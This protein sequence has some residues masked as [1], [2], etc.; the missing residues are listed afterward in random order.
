MANTINNS[1]PLP[2]LDSRY[3]DTAALQKQSPA[4][5]KTAATVDSFYNNQLTKDYNTVQN[6]S[7]SGITDHQSEAKLAADISLLQSMEKQFAG[8]TGDTATVNRLQANPDQTTEGVT[9]NQILEGSGSTHAKDT[10]FTFTGSGT[11]GNQQIEAHLKDDPSVQGTAAFDTTDDSVA[12]STSST[13]KGKDWSVSNSSGA[14]LSGGRYDAADGKA[15]YDQLTKQSN[16]T[17]DNSSQLTALQ[18]ADAFTY[19]KTLPNSQVQADTQTHKG[20]QSIWQKGSSASFDVSQLST[21]TDQF[22]Q[23]TQLFS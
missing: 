7:N 21:N 10:D 18:R 4:A 8:D 1:K 20:L 14:S 22:N 16:V 9:T 2:K 3:T 17:V 19:M 12:A 11:A 23:L 13:G 5:Q 6:N 15:V